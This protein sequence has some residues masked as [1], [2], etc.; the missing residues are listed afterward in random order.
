MRFS[1]YKHMLPIFKNLSLSQTHQEVF[2]EVC[3]WNIIFFFLLEQVNDQ[4]R[5]TGPE[6]PDRGQEQHG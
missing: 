2:C 1:N 4:S 3:K 5:W 6:V